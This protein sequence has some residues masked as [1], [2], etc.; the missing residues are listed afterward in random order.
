MKKI[1]LLIICLL[2]CIG[3]VSSCEK[4]E[5]SIMPPDDKTT[6]EYYYFE[7]F[8]QKTI[9]EVESGC[10]LM[11]SY[12]EIVDF[13]ENLGFDLFFFGTKISE[14]DFEDSYI[15]IAIPEDIPK[16]FMGYTN[17]VSNE[18]GCWIEAHSVNVCSDSHVY[19]GGKCECV[20]VRNPAVNF[21]E[22]GP[23][24]RRIVFDIIAIPKTKADIPID[25]NTEI[26]VY[27]FK[28]HAVQKI[29]ISN[30]AA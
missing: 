23:S 10:F 5:D 6:P 11:E 7:R 1:T 24:E 2:L 25:K 12:D 4:S 29:F 15:L 8:S 19:K 16:R 30:Y 22:V 9:K 21:S 20:D 13:V 27:E 26:D 17:F 14:K 28:Y 18:N 3:F